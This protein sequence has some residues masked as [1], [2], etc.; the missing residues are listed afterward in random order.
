MN[1]LNGVGWPKA[2]HA[3]RPGRAETTMALTR[4]QRTRM[5][6]SKQD[7]VARKKGAGKGKGKGKG[8]GAVQLTPV[9]A[10]AR[11]AVRGHSPH[12]SV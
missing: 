4:E 10:G 2:A 11:P 9:H 8:K 3:W 1:L 6:Q 12:L 7:A 5:D